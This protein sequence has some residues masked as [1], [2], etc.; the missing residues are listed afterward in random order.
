MR[1][2]LTHCLFTEKSQ[3][4]ISQGKKSRM[5]HSMEMSAD[6]HKELLRLRTKDSTSRQGAL[7]SSYVPVSFTLIKKEGQQ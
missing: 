2:Y 5:Y 4:G 7:L 3:S 1:Q 6:G